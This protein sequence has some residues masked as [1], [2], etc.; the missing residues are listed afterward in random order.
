MGSKCMRTGAANCAS[1]DFGNAADKAEDGGLSQ[2]LA[3]DAPA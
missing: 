3:Q 1:A 2:Q